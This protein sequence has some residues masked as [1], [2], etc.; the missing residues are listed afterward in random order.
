MDANPNLTYAEF[1]QV[2]EQDFGRDLSGLYRKEWD[3]VTLGGVRNITPQMWRQFEAE[4][5][6]KSRRVGDIT[7]RE[8]EDRIKRELP[9]DL[10]LRLGEE[11]LRISSSRFWV[12]VYEPLPFSIERIQAFMARLVGKPDLV[13]E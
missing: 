13:L 9:E 3:K 4:C 2:L 5:E 1:W 7:D 10:R 12:K 6:V 11:N 8:R